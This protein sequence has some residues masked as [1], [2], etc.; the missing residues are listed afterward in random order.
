M[1]LRIL[2]AGGQVGKA[3]TDAARRGR[4]PYRAFGRKQC[5]VTDA[6][7][8]E[9]AIRGGRW[10]VN[11]SAYTAVDQA[12]TEQEAAHRVNAIGPANIAAACA[13]AG[14]PLLHIST[15]YVFDG[16]SP[17][18]AREDDPPRPLSV[19]GRSKLGGETAVRE[20]LGRHIILRTSWVFSA[21]GENFVRTILR[22]ARTQSEV[23]VVNDQVGG[24]TAAHDVA[25]AILTIIGAA[26]RE[27][28]VG[29]GTYHY[30]GTPAVS[31]YEFACAIV[32]GSGTAVSPIATRNYPRPARRPMNSVLDCSRIFR[33]FGIRQPDWPPALATVREA[34]AAAAEGGSRESRT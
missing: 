12:E 14:V 19:Y 26:S 18:P 4:I 9:G 8:V 15:D 7:A 27:G 1:E 24:P 2:G 13:A 22:L 17:H 29:W 23:R 5:D 32:A 16:E 28:F 6:H 20:A 30:A 33:V 31:W 21:H 25:G 10:V 34:L 3:L 11:C